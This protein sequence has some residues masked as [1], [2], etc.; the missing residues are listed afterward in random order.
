MVGIARYPKNLDALR[1]GWRWYRIEDE[2]LFSPLSPI[3]T[4][5]PQSGCLR[6]VYV[7]PEAENIWYVTEMIAAQRA[8]DIA[9]T[10]G[11]VSGPFSLDPDMPRIGSVKV[12]SY[13]AHGIFTRHHVTLDHYDLP[14][15]RDYDLAKLQRIEHRVHSAKAG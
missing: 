15:C 13:Q 11:A 7:V 9:L 8:Y 14:I 5:M 2:R 3:R 4:V 1:F 6:D 12:G 10:F